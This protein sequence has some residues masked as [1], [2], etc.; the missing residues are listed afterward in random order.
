MDKVIEIF[1]KSTGRCLI[2]GALLLVLCALP[3]ACGGGDDD[4]TGSPPSNAS[5]SGEEWVDAGTFYIGAYEASR[6][7]AMV[8]FIGNDTSMACSKKGVMPW[9][10]VSWFEA[11]YACEARGARLCYFT[12]WANACGGNAMTYYPYGEDFQNVCN[13][14]EAGYVDYYALPTGSLPACRSEFGVYDMSGNVKEWTSKDG[15]NPDVYEC[16]LTY[17]LGGS[18]KSTHEDAGG[19]ALSCVEDSDSANKCSHDFDFG[20]RCCKD[21]N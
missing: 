16:G 12:E 2:F 5:C 1:G 7:D 6:P 13:S 17:I 9:T 15:D 21:K 18:Y 20:F 14:K 19:R 3:V 11:Y 10:D 4:G 8:D